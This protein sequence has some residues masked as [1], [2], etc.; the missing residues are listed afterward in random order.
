MRVSLQPSQPRKP[1]AQ[2]AALQVTIELLAHKR[3][4]RDR[5]R[6]NFDI[7]PERPSSIGPKH[8]SGSGLAE[9][10]ASFYATLLVGGR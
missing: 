3:R 9:P 2:H 7:G 4:Q 1:T 5:K 10:Q 8:P 6:A